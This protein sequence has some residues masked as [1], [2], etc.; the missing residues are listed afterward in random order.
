[1]LQSKRKSDEGIAA[2]AGHVQGDAEGPEGKGRIS[3][4][5]LANSNGITC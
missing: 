1:M 2:V 4:F 5:D 3:Y